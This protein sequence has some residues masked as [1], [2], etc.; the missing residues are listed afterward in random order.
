MEAVELKVGDTVRVADPATTAS[1]EVGAVRGIEPSGHIDVLFPH[2]NNGP[3]H[4]DR[5]QLE[6]VS[7]E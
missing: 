3:V 5:G 1:G 2:R 7:P 4:Y 6:L